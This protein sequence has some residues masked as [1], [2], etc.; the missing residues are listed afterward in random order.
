VVTLQAERIAKGRKDPPEEIRRG[1]LATERLTDLSGAKRRARAVLANRLATL[2][3]LLEL[4]LTGAAVAVDRVAIIALFTSVEDLIATEGLP[5]IFTTGIGRK[6]VVSQS[7]IAFLPG[8]RVHKPIAALCQRTIIIAERRLAAIV[9][10]FA[11][12]NHLVT[13]V[14]GNTS[15]RIDRAIGVAA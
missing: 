12:V 10:L 14:S 6:V 3:E 15:G 2:L 4:T 1:R 9:T 11:G 8:E 5:A 13:A 7:L